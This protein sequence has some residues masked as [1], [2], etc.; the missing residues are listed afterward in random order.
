MPA[1]ADEI[2]PRKAGLWEIHTVRQEVR[3]RRE[4]T[5]GVPPKAFQEC[6]DASTDQMLLLKTGFLSICPTRTVQRSGDAVS[7]ASACTIKDRTAKAET[8]ET[9]TKITGRLDSAYTVFGTY[10][11]GGDAVPTGWAEM[12]EMTEAKW[13]GPCAAG[14]KPGDVIRDDGSKVNVLEPLQPKK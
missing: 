14:Q 10:A 6:I 9:H 3:T 1:V 11:M 5:I 13:L 4:T 2:P 7:I 8:A 12:S